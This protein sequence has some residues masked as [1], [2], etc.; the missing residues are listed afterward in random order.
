MKSGP[1]VLV[2]RIGSLGDTLVS[3]PALYA[4]RRHFGD[5]AHICLLRNSGARGLVTPDEL[6]SPH[7][8]VDSFVD[9]PSNVGPASRVAAI[10]RLV[11][12]IRRGQFDAAVYLA[13]AARSAWAVR[14]DRVFYRV[15]GIR[16]LLGFRVFA[17]EDLFPHEDDGRLSQVR[18]EGRFL[19][20][21]L[22]ADGLQP[23]EEEGKLPLSLEL[24]EAERM[25]AREWLRERGWHEGGTLIAI[26]PG[27]KMP[28]NRWALSRFVQVGDVLRRRVPCE[29]VVVGGR[30]ERAAGQ[31]LLA[32]WGGGINAAG[33]FSVRDSAALLEL[34]HLLLGLDTGTTHLAAAVGTPCVGIYGAR[35]NPGRWHPMGQGHEILRKDEA[36]PCAGCLLED[37]P[38]P[39]SHCTLLI[40]ADEVVEAAL[41]VL[42]KRRVTLGRGG[43]VEDTLSTTSPGER[44]RTG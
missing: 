20:D 17:R 2:F 21:R 6:L 4:I 32:E 12:R 36:V 31:R 16:R 30:R 43:S 35:D 9:Y 38:R 13:P 33:A 34:C 25:R 18:S 14:R 24:T 27:S 28:V 29:L 40:S 3:V 39:S 5:E 37:C 23:V 10:L 26:A 11:V 42:A 19:L 1:R 22:G 7:S 8:C 15:C 41:R 44:S